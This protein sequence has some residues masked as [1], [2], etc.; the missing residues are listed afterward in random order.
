[1]LEA[2]R[3]KHEAGMCRIWGK[4]TQLCRAHYLAHKMRGMQC[5]AQ[6]VW[7]FESG[8]WLYIYIRGMTHS[9]AAA[10]AGHTWQVTPSKAI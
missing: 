7:D 6:H 4:L 1:M 2:G 8:G 9:C 5:R 3:S 10:A